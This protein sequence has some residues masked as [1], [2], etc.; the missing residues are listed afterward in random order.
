MALGRGIIGPL[1]ACGAHEAAATVDGATRNSAVPAWDAI[2][3]VDEAIAQVRA[4]LGP[5]FD[6]TAS[7]GEKLTDDEL[8]QYLERAVADL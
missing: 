6:A 8:V 4:E 5:S 1:V 3:T 2:T 7:R